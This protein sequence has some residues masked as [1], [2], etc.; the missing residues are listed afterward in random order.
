MPGV[1]IVEAL[2][3]AGACAVLS[4]EAYRGKIL[5]L[6]AVTAKFRSKVVPGDALR[7]EVEFTRLK[8]NAGLGLGTAYVGDR[9]AAEAEI[10]FLIG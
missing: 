8:K 5:Y 1:L 3:Q 7:L 10:T 9:K 4:L 2:A 6:G